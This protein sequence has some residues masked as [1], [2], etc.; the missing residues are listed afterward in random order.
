M[1]FVANLLYSYCNLESDVL[2]CSRMNIDL[3]TVFHL[4]KKVED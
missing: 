2:S 4:H 1:L 3:L